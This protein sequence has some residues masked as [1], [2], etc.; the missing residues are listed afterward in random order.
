[1]MTL[2][3]LYDKKSCTFTPAVAYDS[4]ATAH[5]AFI[6]LLAAGD[7]TPAQWPDDFDLY[8]LGSFDSSSG[9]LTPDPR[10]SCILTGQSALLQLSALRRGGAV[11]GVSTK[12]PPED[13]EASAERNGDSDTST[14]PG[15]DVTPELP[16]KQ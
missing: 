2:C 10:P 8:R 1:M 15:R 6:G 3:S 7:S 13:S 12:T 4:I 5:R 11:G 9:I 14:F 16:L